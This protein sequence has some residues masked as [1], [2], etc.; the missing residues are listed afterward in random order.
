MVQDLR[1][2]LR[3]L[4]LR[5]AIGA[6]G[7]DIVRLVA[8]QGGVPVLAGLAIGIAATAALTGYLTSLL[9]EV[10]PADPLTMIAAP[11]LLLAAALSAMA[12]PALNAAAVDPM[13]ALRDE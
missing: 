3:E 6:R 7:R 11:A 2:A 13:V 4:G 10:S 5:M 9:F 12:K 8:V 1:Y